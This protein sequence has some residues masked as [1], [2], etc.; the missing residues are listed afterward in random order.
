MANGERATQYYDLARLQPHSQTRY[1]FI[2]FTVTTI[3]IR[4]RTVNMSLNTKYLT[5]SLVLI[6]SLSQIYFNFTSFLLQSLNFFI[7]FFKIL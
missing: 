5:A 6:A 1:A 7:F 2:T 4:F 3:T